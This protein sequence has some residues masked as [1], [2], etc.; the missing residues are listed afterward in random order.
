MKIMWL[1]GYS[2]WPANHGGKI[3]LYNLVKQMLDRG[4]TIDLWCITNED[5]QWN[6]RP[7]A[8]LHLRKFAAKARDTVP[9]KVAAMLSPLPQ[10][11]WSVGTPE[12]EA[13][14]AALE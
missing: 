11:P 7:P 2:P 5:V 3:R 8:A 13:E 14:V 4:H 12:V 10:P 1:R 6:G 9:Q